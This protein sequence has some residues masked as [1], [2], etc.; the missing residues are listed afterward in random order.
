MHGAQFSRVHII[1]TVEIDGDVV[2]SELGQVT[3]RETV[4]PTVFAEET[5]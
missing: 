3:P 1:Q 5:P 2:S 4:D